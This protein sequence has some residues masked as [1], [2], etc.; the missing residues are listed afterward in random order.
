MSQSLLSI[1]GEP[2]ERVDRA[3]HAL[4]QGHGILLVDDEDRENE[5]DLI[6]STDHLNQQ[7]IAMMIREC[8][9]IICLCLTDEKAKS[10]NLSPMVE[11]NN[12]QFGT[13]FTAS[14]EA[15][16]GVTTGV[17][18]QDRLTTILTAANHQA[19]ASDICSPGHVFPLRANPGGVQVRRG[20]T[21]GT[22]ELMKLSGLSDSG[23]LCELTN[24]DGSMAKL[25]EIV[26]FALKHD[27]VV[28]SIEDIVS[29]QQLSIKHVV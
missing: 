4:Q 13:A 24:E 12:S 18:A 16:H 9:G 3:I 2:V 7:Q 23:V 1:F 6:F 20:H 22:I 29:Y 28:L 8:S 21:E 27:M 17:S 15:C 14:I 26:S 19:K 5:G 25:K 10:L 11:H